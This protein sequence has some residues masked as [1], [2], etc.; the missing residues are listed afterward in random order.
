MIKK[1]KMNFNFLFLKKGDLIQLSV[2]RELDK[3]EDQ[4]MECL[5][6]LVLNHRDK[7]S[8]VK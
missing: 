3:R 2:V 6:E 4:L 5:C 1:I 8:V 7:I